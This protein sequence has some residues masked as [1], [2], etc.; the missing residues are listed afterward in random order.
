M[1]K[2]LVLV[3]QGQARELLLY[4]HLQH[5]VGVVVDRVQDAEDVLVATVVDRRGGTVRDHHR[6]LVLLGDVADGD[7]DTAAI[8]AKQKFH[9]VLGDQLFVQLDRGVHVA[10]IVV[11][12]DLDL[13]FLAGDLHPPALVHRLHEEVV[14]FS[15]ELT[16]GREIAGERQ[17]RAEADRVLRRGRQNCRQPQQHGQASRK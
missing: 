7:R 15:H 11:V 8:R 4:R 10:L 17:R 13:V 6:Q 2:K 12:D 9:L 3:E 14:A 16:F 1:G 5:V